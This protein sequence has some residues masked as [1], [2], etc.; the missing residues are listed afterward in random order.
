MKKLNWQKLIAMLLIS[1]FASLCLA[2]CGGGG[3]G[4]G[5]SAGP[6][7][8]AAAGAGVAPDES[9][10][11]DPGAAGPSSIVA[12]V[13]TTI[14]DSGLDPI[15][16]AMSYGYPFTNAALLK[17]APAST[18]GG[19]LAVAWTVSDDGLVYTFDLREGVRFSDGSALTAEDVVFTY[20]TVRERQA[21]NESADLTRLAAV[22]AL[23]DYR[24]EF[25]LAEPFSPFLDTAAILGIAPSDAYDSE[26]FDHYPIGAGPWRILQY[27]ANQQIIA[28]A[29]PYYYDKAPAID[30]V[31]LVYMDNDAALAAAR[32]GQLDVVM[33]SPNYATETVSGMRLLP[34]ETMDVRLVSLPTQRSLERDGQATGNDV[35]ADS[36]VRQAL[37]IGIDR[38]TIIQNAF[39]GVGRPATGFTGNLIWAGGLVYED[40][41]KAEA[42]ALLESAGWIDEDGDGYREK[43]GVACEFDLLAAEDRYGLAAALAE[44]AAALGI[45]INPQAASWG[46][47]AARM[48]SA[49]VVWGWGQYSPTVVRSLF[50]SRGAFSGGFDNVVG[51]T[52]PRVDELIDQALAQVSQEAAVA[53]WKQAQAIADQDYPYLYIVN[54]EHCYFVSDRLDISLDTQIPHPHGHGSPIICNM[55]DWTLK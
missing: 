21:E 29:N 55:K 8:S 24:V 44:D 15:K 54:I 35:T 28:A 41:R 13:G 45:K 25:T 9:A 47:I 3:P 46:D 48:N 39:N 31:T 22:R 16:G 23:G 12:Y 18:Y 1:T 38:E 32:S 40:N 34:L 50:D 17:V 19:D 42:A 36:H 10:A 27:D 4:G 7:P 52:N 6:D 5:S 20:E 43:D 49:G 30:R 37:A 26:T 53:A 11:P 51:Y 14:F 2:G 33:V